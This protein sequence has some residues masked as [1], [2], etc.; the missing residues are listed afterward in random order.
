MA[1]CWFPSRRP[2]L[3]AALCNLLALFLLIQE[4]A[5]GGIPAKLEALLA[6]PGERTDDQRHGRHYGTIHVSATDLQ[7]APASREECT[8]PFEYFS[9]GFEG[10]VSRT[11][12]PA[13]YWPPLDAFGK[14]RL[15]ILCHLH[16]H[17]P[18]TPP[19]RT[20]CL[21]ALAPGE[22]IIRHAAAIAGAESMKNFLHHEQ[23]G[24]MYEARVLALGRV[25]ELSRADPASAAA[26]LA[27]LASYCQDTGPPTQSL[28]KTARLS[29]GYTF[30]IQGIASSNMLGWC[31]R[32]LQDIWNSAAA[33]P[34]IATA[35]LTEIA[36][37][38]QKTV[39]DTF[40]KNFAH[41]NEA[42]IRPLLAFLGD[43]D[44]LCMETLLGAPADGWP[45]R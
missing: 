9:R 36:R 14:N 26:A 20:L 8:F 44:R 33:S 28:L 15:L 23:L 35:T 32:V 1:R 21:V 30:M 5:Q 12:E 43:E 31:D 37:Q 34:A 7:E 38:S 4:M 29:L 24:L 27:Q 40:W 22:S 16:N 18:N 45:I 11:S 10:Y 17:Q 41:A 13:P 2:I 3:P 42:T 19:E 6:T 25:I 39:D